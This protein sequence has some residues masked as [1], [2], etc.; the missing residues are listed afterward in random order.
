M[1][2]EMAAFL[3]FIVPLQKKWKPRANIGI[4]TLLFMGKENQQNYTH[5]K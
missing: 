2:S 5:T 4:M 1:R 3:F